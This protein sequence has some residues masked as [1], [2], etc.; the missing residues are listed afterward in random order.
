MPVKPPPLSWPHGVLRFSKPSPSIIEGNPYSTFNSWVARSFG[1]L[2]RNMG[3]T[4]TFTTA[5][6][7]DLTLE[8]QRP[9]LRNAAFTTTSERREDAG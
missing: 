2:P 5:T 7:G 6:P 4:I 8:Q 1:V 9:S 3:T